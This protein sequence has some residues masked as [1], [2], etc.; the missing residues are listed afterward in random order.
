MIEWNINQTNLFNF[1]H[2]SNYK[3]FLFF[4]TQHSEV[5]NKQI[6]ITDYYTTH[7]D[8]KE[9]IDDKPYKAAVSD[10]NTF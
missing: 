10:L 7:C 5:L 9:S 1:K 4:L 3:T 2:L 6:L 8:K